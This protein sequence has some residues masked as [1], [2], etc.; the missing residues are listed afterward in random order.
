M[1]DMRLGLFLRSY[2]PRNAG[3]DGSH[4]PFLPGD[5]ID[6]GGFVQPPAVEIVPSGGI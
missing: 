1:N 6:D 4:I 3:Q 5:V 2:R